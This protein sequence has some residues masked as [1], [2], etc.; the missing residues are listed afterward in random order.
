MGYLVDD[1]LPEHVVHLLAGPS[2]A[3]KT[4][5]LLTSLM[6][7]RKGRPFLDKPSRPGEWLY[8][9]ADRGADEVERMLE[10]MR[11]DRN[12]VPLVPAFGKDYK[13]INEIMDLIVQ[14]R[15]RLAVVEAFASFVD[16]NHKTMVKNYLNRWKRFCDEAS[17]TIIGIVESPKMTPQKFYD[18][19]RQR[20]SG[21]ADWGHFASTIIIA[22]FEDPRDPNGPRRLWICPRDYPSVQR[23]FTF[24]F[25]GRPMLQEVEDIE[26][27]VSD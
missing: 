19:P 24:D 8:I 16:S 26:I 14:R 25:H 9:S 11:V 21:V 1:L 20:V 5:W 18:N 10:R 17:T 13:N 15:P 22:E 23:R 27:P 12:Q 4:R 7:W 6:E 3:G 2:G